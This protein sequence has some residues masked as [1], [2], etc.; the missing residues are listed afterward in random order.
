MSGDIRKRWANQ[1]LPS[2]EVD[3]SS[4]ESTFV[5]FGSATRDF[6]SDATG[7]VADVTLG[8]TVYVRATDENENSKRAVGVERANFYSYIAGDLYTGTL[9]DYAVATEFGKVSGFSASMGI[10]LKDLSAFIEDPTAFVDGIKAL[11]KL[12]AEGDVD[13]QAI[14]DGYVTQFQQ[15]QAQNN[16]YDPTDPDEEHLHTAFKAS[17]Y[18]GYA[19][20]FVAKLVISAGLGKAAKTAIKQTDTVGDI[21]DRLS[22]TGAARALS[23]IDSAKEASKARAT[24]RILLAV[25][26]A[27]PERLLSQADTAGQAYRL[28]QLQRGMDADAAQ[29]ARFSTTTINCGPDW[30]A[31]PRS[32]RRVHHRPITTD[33]RT[34]DQL[35]YSDD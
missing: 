16:P 33:R 30:T 3:T 15:K 17:W 11:L 12:L 29:E 6:A 31:T 8:T 7:A 19:A 32:I 18:E 34:V 26:G 2:E 20:G 28:W 35:E 1:A 9:L 25:D 23:R 10:F 14:I 13:V 21:A 22:D 27:V 4:I 24:A 5:S